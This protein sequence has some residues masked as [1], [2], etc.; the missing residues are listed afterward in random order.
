MVVSEWSSNVV[1]CELLF[2]IRMFQRYTVR[3]M[4]EIIGKYTVYGIPLWEL[5]LY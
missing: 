5:L 1:W 2:V 3:T 4:N